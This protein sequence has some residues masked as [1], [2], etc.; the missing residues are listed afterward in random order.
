MNSAALTLNLP[1]PTSVETANAHFSQPQG[2]YTESESEEH[3]ASYLLALPICISLL[4]SGFSVFLLE[5]HLSVVP[6]AKV[7]ESSTL[8]LSTKPLFHFPSR[9]LLH[10]DTEFQVSAC[11][12]PSAL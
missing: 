12:S 1:T 4:P 10:M 6:S 9:I 7:H 2:T 11:F 3:I 8:P 5:V